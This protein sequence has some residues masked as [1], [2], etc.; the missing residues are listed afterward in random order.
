MAP[1]TSMLKTTAREEGPLRT[2]VE[3]NGKVA[4]KVG[5]GVRIN[6]VELTEVKESKN[7]TRFNSSGTD[8]LPP[9][10]RDY[11]R[12]LP[13]LRPP[14]KEQGWAICAFLLINHVI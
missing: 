7:S 13:I 1:L 10:A 8:F 5:G 11:E 9:E 2:A 6:R 3:V 14:V 12:P 4:G